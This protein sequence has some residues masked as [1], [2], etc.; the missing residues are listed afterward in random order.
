MAGYGKSK[1]NTYVRECR[2]LGVNEL[3]L[4][5]G[6]GQLTWQKDDGEVVEDVNYVYDE[7]SLRLK[8][9]VTTKSPWAEEKERHY[10]YE[11]SIDYTE[12]NFGGK[13]PWFICPGKGCDNRVAKLYRPPGRDVFACRDCHDLTYESQ[14]KS[15]TMQYEYIDRWESKCYKILDE[16]DADY[17]PGIHGLPY[18]P[19][20]PKGM[21][22]DTYRELLDRYTRYHERVLAG[23][24]RGVRELTERHDG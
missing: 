20:R 22:E 15:N 12:P 7:S 5:P 8:Y 14:G 18:H 6:T 17:G 23:F 19:E 2:V 16:L 1:E 24:E 11:I 4:E 21:H 13:R 9:V 10:D 3:D